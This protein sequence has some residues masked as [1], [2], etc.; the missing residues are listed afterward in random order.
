[1]KI[2]RRLGTLLTDFLLKRREFVEY[3]DSEDFIPSLIISLV[4]YPSKPYNPFAIRVSLLS[5]G[6]SEEF[7]VCKENN[8]NQYYWFRAYTDEQYKYYDTLYNALMSLELYL[9]EYLDTERA[10]DTVVEF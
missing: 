10:W 7:M 6:F 4:K 3:V 2:E 8:C 5:T 9:M 1:M